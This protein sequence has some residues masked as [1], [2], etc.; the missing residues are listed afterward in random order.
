MWELARSASHGVSS[1]RR[2]L[3]F[4]LA[5]LITVFL[6]TTVASSTAQAA[7]GK[8]HWV[9]N[10]LSYQGNQY[11]DAGKAAAGNSAGIPDGSE[12][13][14]FT[15]SVNSPSATPKTDIIYFAANKTPTKETSATF[16]VYTTNPS[17][18]PPTYSNPQNK[19]TL[20]VETADQ[21]TDGGTTCAIQSIGWIVCPVSETLA[22]GM[23][24]IMGVLGQF[25]AVQPLNVT[26][27]KNDLYT[28]WNIM[29]SIANVAFIIVFL[30]IIYSQLTS[31]GINNYGLKKLLPRLIIA[32]VIVNL[33]YFL[34]AIFVDI[35]NI[36]G[37]SIQGLLTSM[38]DTVF[39]ATGPNASTS[40][41]DWTSVTSL[42]LAGGSVV[43]GTIIGGVA[44]NSAVI[45]GSA[46]GLFFLLLPAL[47][48]LFLAVMVVLLILAA[49]QAIIIILIV[50]S[51]LA[52]VAYL[53]PNTEKWF[54]QWR[55]LFTT[56]MVFFPG[57]SVVFAGSQLA[58]AVIIKNAQSMT[59]VVLGMIVQVAP[60]AIT[61]WL[62]RLSGSA[63]QNIAKFAQ[64]FNKR[65]NGAV[66]D[67]SKTRREMHRM[68]GLSSPT[69][70]PFRRNA[71]FFYSR[72]QRVKDRTAAYT[73]GADNMHK[74]TRRFEK[75]D[76]MARGFDQ[77]KHIIEK[78]HDAHWKEYQETNRMAGR[79]EIQLRQLTD[80][81]NLAGQRLDARFEELSAEGSNSRYATIAGGARLAEDIKLTSQAISVQGLRIQAAKNMQQKYLA[82][83]LENAASLPLNASNNILVEATGIDPNGR[84]RARAN[85]IA[86]LTKIETEARENTIKFLTGQAIRKGQTI[87][88]YANDIT[89]MAHKNQATS[90][91]FDGTMVEAAL[92]VLAQDG[93]VLAMERALMNPSHSREIDPEMVA[94]VLQRNADTMKK[95]GGFHAQ[96][97]PSDLINAK[98]EKMNLKRAG[99]LGNIT[100]DHIGDAKFSWYA[101]VSQNIGKIIDDVKSKA[102]SKDEAKAILTRIY[103]STHGALTDKG[104]RASLSDRL[105]EAYAIE[106]AI[107]DELG[108]PKA[109]RDKKNKEEKEAD[110]NVG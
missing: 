90:N 26:D 39:H 28:A 2:M 83:A 58:S 99:T 84:V 3:T 5:V 54:E 64:G 52:F 66:G 68:K 79:R 107:A 50:V 16:A 92:E 89:D 40:N 20:S 23:D 8:I 74:R 103:D 37:T 55:K 10:N 49:R 18:S 86:A 105:T 41:S 76:M 109:T 51:P 30:V 19:T 88:Q 62:L 45:G 4:V 81:E 1:V 106:S 29:R 38:R 77:D 98:P 80:R 96:N 95:K 82:E 67:W 9:G 108:K 17:N 65:I 24:W 100:S 59:V 93:D 15:E 22:S 6:W 35:S 32:A 75:V 101:Y 43:A 13:Y 60:L 21:G 42:A 71:Q 91:G 27:T 73:T 97:D 53:L 110:G 57:F 102:E 14:T 34:C 72:G 104:T 48:A 87:K 63:I 78:S 61:P 25:V 56:M 85:A 47:I 94:K 36:I 69:A 33:S 12:Y 11:T 46:G 70:N 44:L 7:N 31:S